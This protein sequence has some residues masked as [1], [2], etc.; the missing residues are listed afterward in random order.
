[1]KIKRTTKFNLRKAIEA[2]QLNNIR[3]IQKGIKDKE[4][5]KK[6]KNEYLRNQV[7]YKTNFPTEKDF[8]DYVLLEVKKLKPDNP[9]VLSRFMEDVYKQNIAELQQIEFI[10]NYFGNIF[11]NNYNSNINDAIIKLPTGGKKSLFPKDGNITNIRTK[12]TK[13]IDLFMVY[14]FNNDK[15]NIYASLKHTEGVG[16]EQDNQFN[17]LK[18][19]GKEFKKINNPNILTLCI[20]SGSYYERNNYKKVNEL[21]SISDSSSNF[22]VY[23]S[24]VGHVLIKYIVNWLGGKEN[25]ESEINRL[26]QEYNNI[27]DEDIEKG[28]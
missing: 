17:D 27:Y 8:V 20:V 7:V 15:I 9:F 23:I 10:K 26:L 18:T 12:D 21:Q 19:T 25:S 4:I 11:I 1:M 22:N 13:S 3:D 16:G 24:D 5:M 28:N 6:A 2:K 14:T